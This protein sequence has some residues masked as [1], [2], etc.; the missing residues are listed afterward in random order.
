VAK[1][2]RL[3]GKLLA[4]ACFGAL[5]L[6]NVLTAKTAK[7]TARGGTRR[8][9]KV[10]RPAS[11]H[12]PAKRATVVASTSHRH[13]VHSRHGGSLGTVDEYLHVRKGDTLESL[14]AARGVGITEARDWIAAAA[15]VFDLTKIRPR[16]GLTLRFDRETHAIESIR[17][18]IDGKYLLVAEL[19][20]DGI[21]ARREDLPYFVE[22]KGV[23]GTI[24][25]GLREDTV[26]SGV[27]PRIAADV[28]DIF[29]WD[30]DV[31]SGLHAGDE[32][33]VIYE[34]IWQVGMSEPQAGKV[35]AAELVIDGKS[36]TAMLFE[37]ED[38][39]GGYYAPT[40]EAISRTF[41]RYPVEFTEISSEYSMDRFHPIRHQ[42]RP[43]W[44]VD[45]AAPYGTPVRAAADGVVTAV[46]WE[47]GLGNTIRIDHAGGVASAYGHLSHFAPAANESAKVERGQVIGYVGSTGL[48]TGPHLHYEI[49]R[50]GEHTNPLEFTCEREPSIAPPLVR[51][52]DRTRKEAVKQLA[53]LPSA[54]APTSLSLSTTLFQAE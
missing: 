47:T 21:T 7:R 39:Q 20:G 4:L 17:Y 2:Q 24:S 1:D 33:R 25:H 34:N 35:L 28:A 12:R 40:G 49:A 19:G 9:A 14:L 36:Q 8:V 5:L 6:P 26:A 41:L 37:D 29:A 31:E 23:A 46:G 32:Y 27:P 54:T 48:S 51:Q 18:E 42:R 45:L 53:A 11:C 15:D 38:G 44:G 22:V 3:V 10:V 50:D 43:H 30:V 52:F 16:H 13:R